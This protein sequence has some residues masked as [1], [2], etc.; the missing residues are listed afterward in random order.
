LTDPLNQA[1]TDVGTARAR[2]L[3]TA[4]TVKARLS[5]AALKDEIVEKVQTRAIEVASD[6]ANI[7]NKRPALTAGVFATAALIIL[8]KPVIGVLQRLFKEK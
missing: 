3:G 5:P 1:E 6:L 2:L 4:S 8:R 7:V